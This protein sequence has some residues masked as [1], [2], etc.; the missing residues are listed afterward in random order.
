MHR[1]P[2]EPLDA[3]LLAGG[4]LVAGGLATVAPWQVAIGAALVLALACARGSSLRVTLASGALVAV[5]LAGARGRL[6]LRR[7]RALVAASEAARR[8]ALAAVAQPAR[9]SA[10]GEVI[11]S[12]VR[13]RDSLR[14]DARVEALVCD[15]VA[16]AWAGPVTLYGG[17]GDLARGDV[18]GRRRHPPRPAA[19][20]LESSH[21]RPSPLR[22]PTRRGPHGRRPRRPRLQARPRRRRP[23]STASGPASA[24][25]SRPFAPDVAPMAR[26]LVLGESDLAAA[27][28]RAS[29][30]AVS[31]TCS[32]SPACTSCSRWR[33]ASCRPRSSGSSHSLRGS[34]S[35]ASPRWPASRWR[36][37]TPSL[38]AAADPPSA[39]HGWPRRPS[40]RA[41]SGG[42]PDRTRSFGLS[43][44]VMAL[45]DPLVAPRPVLSPSPQGPPRG[46]SSSPVQARRSSRRRRAGP[47]RVVSRAPS[48]PRSQP[49]CRAPRFS[50]ALPL[51][52]RSAGSS[53]TSSPCPSGSPLRSRCASL[54]L[55]SRGGRRPSRGVRRSRPGPSPSS[56]WWRA[57]SPSRGSRPASPSPRRGSSSRSRSPSLRS[58]SRAPCAAAS[59]PRQRPRSCYSRRTRAPR[60][61]REASSAPRS[62]TSARATRP[63]SIFRRRRP[64]LI[65]GGG[66][67]RQSDRRRR[68]RP[69]ARAPRAPPGRARGGDFTAPAPGPLWRPGHRARLRPCRRALGYRRG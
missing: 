66:P 45:V 13:V 17:P 22:G 46:S 27:T 53:R 18:V 67:R 59:S 21:R 62:S 4:A 7:G 68:P 65:D 55:S 31:R 35:A 38:R 30:R 60:A 57:R 1:A 47:R 24:A 39:L 2:A 61:R 34:M 56:G 43:I 52:C 14:W 9:C 50:P 69:R 25:G 5:V 41:R 33:C 49:R 54:T 51:R 10:R 32:R 23:G 36:G 64:S 42:A 20:P 44:G 48:P 6:K 29:G 37:S 63:S 40:A 12:P 3:T 15:G 8:E 58:P 16:V 19:T 28:T 11:S 26:A